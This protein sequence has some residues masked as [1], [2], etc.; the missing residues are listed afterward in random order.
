MLAPSPRALS[1]GLIRGLPSFFFLVERGRRGESDAFVMKLDSSGD[2][3]WIVQRGSSMHDG[4]LSM[5]LNSGAEGGRW[6]DAG[7]YMWA[8]KVNR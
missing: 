2:L 3:L 7:E 5:V 4:V 8:S 1:S 6:W